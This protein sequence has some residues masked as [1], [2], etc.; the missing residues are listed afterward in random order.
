MSRPTSTDDYPETKGEA[1]VMVLDY[2][3]MSQ[4]SNNSAGSKQLLP[5]HADL[6]QFMAQPYDTPITTPDDYSAEIR[7]NTAHMG[8]LMRAS[9]N[10][11]ESGMV[12]A[13]EEEVRLSSGSPA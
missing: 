1:D 8:K 10:N 5:Q 11:A 4:M 2:D 6:R 12:S 7:L 13:D 3:D 9:G